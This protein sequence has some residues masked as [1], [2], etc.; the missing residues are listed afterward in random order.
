M[1]FMRLK[2]RAIFKISIILV[3][4]F[5]VGCN[6]PLRLIRRISEGKIVYKITYSDQSSS[7]QFSS[8]LPNEMVIYFKNN[9]VKSVIKGSFNFYSL[10][11][12]SPY[13]GDTSYTFLR[14]MDKKIYFGSA[15]KN[16]MFLFDELKTSDVNLIEG[17][18][19]DFFGYT[20]KKAL[21]TP[22]NK[23]NAPIEVYYT[24]IIKIKNPNANT[25]FNKIPGFLIKFDVFLKNVRYTFTATEITPMTLDD[26]FFKIPP[27]YERIDE[28]EMKST[29][30]NLMQ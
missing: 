21:L 27:K 10:E 12:L 1:D 17:L 25:P 2:N 22:A 16:G 19:K 28:T 20:C 29:L 4:I 6:E 9:N 5:I 11:H 23:T 13:K 30:S 18:E 14:V 3:S 24:D 8:I 26:S 15:K 7:Q